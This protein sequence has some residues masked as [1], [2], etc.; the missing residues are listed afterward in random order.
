MRRAPNAP[1]RA[2]RTIR[3]AVDRLETR[4]L[5]A[6]NLSI[7]PSFVASSNV[8]FSTVGST[9]TVKTK[10]AS[11]QLSISDLEGLL[12]AV[13]VV[14]VVVTTS[15]SATGTNSGEPGSIT[16]DRQF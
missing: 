13:G 14:E 9:T 3:L 5:P 2:R 15:V 4:S 1:H 11:A 8:E 12:Q 10:G 7:A 6:N 16:W